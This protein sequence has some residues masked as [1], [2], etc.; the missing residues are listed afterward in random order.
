MSNSKSG[1]SEA[2]K[3]SKE[4]EVGLNHVR[5]RLKVGVLVMHREEFTYVGRLDAG[6]V[7]SSPASSAADLL[8]GENTCDELALALGIPLSEIERLVAELDRGALLDTKAAKLTVHERFHSPNAHRASHASDDSSDGAFQQLK[9][10]LAPELTSATWLPHVK[11]GGISTID[12]RRSWQVNIYGG[13][14]IATILYGILLSSGITRTRLHNPQE[15]R[16]IAEPDLCAGFLR[17]SDIGLSYRA[18]TDELAREL[19]LFPTSANSSS[20]QKERIVSIVVGTPPSDQLQSWMSNGTAH[21][22]IDNPD[23]ASITVGPLVVP[24][25]TPCTR[26]VCIANEELNGLWRDISWKKQRSA[27]SEVPVAVA[28]HVAGLV[29]LELLRFLDEDKS[30]MIGRSMRINFHTP[31]SVQARLHTR[32]PACGCT[33]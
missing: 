17:A 2:S 10:R 5:P 14:R 11:D 28:H 24:G 25:Q 27:P 4:S 3:E 31:T 18:R 16:T 12:A 21:L 20:S 8:T 13:S 23:G 33:W 1:D 30:E 15:S 6:I 26:C 22:M 29:A 19:S 32:H 9:A 7:I